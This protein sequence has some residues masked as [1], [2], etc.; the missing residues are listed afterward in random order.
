MPKSVAIVRD[1]FTPHST[2]QRSLSEILKANPDGSIAAHASLAH[3]HHRALV[4]QYE[5]GPSG[6]YSLKATSTELLR[7][8]HQQ[9]VRVA[10]HPDLVSGLRPCCDAQQSTNEVPILTQEMKKQ[11]YSDSDASADGF[12]FSLACY[13][14]S[15]QLRCH[16]AL[17]PGLGPGHMCNLA[18]LCQLSWHR[19]GSDHATEYYYCFRLL[20][21]LSNAAIA[22][23]TLQAF[24]CSPG[25]SDGWALQH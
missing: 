14:R 11:S 20:S 19:S 8:L 4:D 9:R 10:L 21:I 17:R 1:S 5:L 24:T 6:N 12:S 25:G 2:P 23:A 3:P 13:A 15:V 18:H 16:H 7:F 22:V